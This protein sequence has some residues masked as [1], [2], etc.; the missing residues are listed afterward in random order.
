MAQSY[1][2]I[3]V[4]PN[5]VLFDLHP[6]SNMALTR[7]IHLTNQTPQYALP[8]DW[9]LGIFQDSA[10]FNMYRKGVFT[11][12]KNEEIAKAAYENGV[13]FGD[14]FDF[15]P[16]KPN[17]AE[18]ILKVLKAGNRKNIQDAISTY[19]IEEVRDVTLA[20]IGDLTQNVINML[21]QILN[22]QL[23]VDKD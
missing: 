15:E 16:A 5:E 20:N 13:Y 23:V 3:K 9:A 10:V 1:K 7:R 4:T 22:M 11:F 18:E 19:G 21:E 2:I 12:D 14:T 6:V 17:R 8:E